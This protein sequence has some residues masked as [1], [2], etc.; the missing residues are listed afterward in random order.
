MRHDATTIVVVDA[1]MR[2]G[3]Q[4]EHA[5][6]QDVGV[7]P[8]V[9]VGAQLD[10]IPRLVRAALALEPE[11][12]RVMFAPTAP[13]PQKLTDGPLRRF[14]CRPATFGDSEQCDRAGSS[15]AA[16]ASE[17]GVTDR[18]G[19]LVRRPPHFANAFTGVPRFNRHTRHSGSH[20]LG[21]SPT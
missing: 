2:T 4:P 18:L 15:A 14:R 11:V 3:E 21:P 19:H 20:A 12:V 13:S 9:M 16:I 1:V 10:Q 7:H 17:H 6:V 8:A 5:G